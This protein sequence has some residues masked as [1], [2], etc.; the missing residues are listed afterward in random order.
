MPYKDEAGKLGF[1]ITSKYSSVVDVKL[2]DSLIHIW[3]SSDPILNK[4][5]TDNG[6]VKSFKLSH[7]DLIMEKPYDM[8]MVITNV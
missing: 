7:K 4:K 5:L 2:L 1:E 6:D 3:R 8:E